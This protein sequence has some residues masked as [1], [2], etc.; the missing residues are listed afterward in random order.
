MGIRLDEPLHK[1]VGDRTAKVL[2]GKLSLETVGDLLRH[3]PRRY[4][5]RGQLTELSE[6]EPGT[7]A[8]IVAQ[9]TKVSRRSMA[10]R[11]GQMMTV[12]VR[13]SADVPVEITFF[14]PRAANALKPGMLGMFAGKIGE[15]HGRIQLTN[16][17]F[18]KLDP[19]ADDADVD[20]WAGELMP[21]YP[22]TSGLSP[23][24]IGR[25]VRMVLDQFDADI[26]DDPLPRP[27]RARQGLLSLT[28]AFRRI[29]R[30]EDWPEI[31]TARKRLKWD[32]ALPMQVVLAQRREALKAL[33]AVPRRRVDGGLLDAFDAALPF[34]LTAG[35]RQV[36]AEI[37]QDL[38]SE[39]PM[40][41]LLQ[42]D[43]G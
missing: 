24:M 43:V 37:E 35:Q 39:H 3:Y 34:T 31:A 23:R 11:R 30:P 2:R 27:V 42:G 20:S 26:E 22:T 25:C 15:Y 8:T 38:A 5:K 32:E 29:H 4:V 41:R 12:E 17:E 10:A 21:I 36:G 33:P 9:V 13:D 6:L 18:E 1:A 16:P 28:E 14:N 40:H 7:E 19:D